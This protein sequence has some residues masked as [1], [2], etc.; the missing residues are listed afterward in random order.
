MGASVYGGSLIAMIVC[1]AL[2]NGGLWPRLG[3]LFRRLDHSAIY[4]KIAGSA[5]T[6][7]RLGFF[8]NHSSMCLAD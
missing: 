6:Y 7:R 5:D 4:F 2:Y 1:S 3:E 8:D